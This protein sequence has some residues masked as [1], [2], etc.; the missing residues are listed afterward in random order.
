MRFG[1][2]CLLANHYVTAAGENIHWAF[3]GFEELRRP[4]IAMVNLECPVTLRGKKVRKPF[5]FR[6]HPRFIAVLKE[7]GIDIVNIANNHIFD[8]GRVGLFDTIAYLD[9]AGMMCVGAG[10]NNAE[11]HRPVIIEASGKRIGFLGYYRGGE[12]PAATGNRPGVAQRK[13]ALIRT[14][15][16]GLKERDSVDYVVV[17]LHWGNEK[18]AAP[19]RWQIELAHDIIDAGADAIIGHHP[20]WLQGIERYKTGVIA[21]SLGNLIFGGNSRGRYDTG[22]F[23]IMLTPSGPRFNFIPVRVVDWKAIVLTGA[24]AE[25]LLRYVRRLSRIFPQTIFTNPELR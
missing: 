12:A 3:E 2:D 18:S 22:L 1:G 21:Y 13:I 7:A 16:R 8:Y 11:A 6:M 4:D 15:I 20:H 19:Q 23:E 24:E 14:D 25:G 10:R 17:N 5:N 9:S